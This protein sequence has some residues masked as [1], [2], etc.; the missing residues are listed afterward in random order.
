MHF[1][2]VSSYIDGWGP[3]PQGELETPLGIGDFATRHDIEDIQDFGAIFRALHS[4]IT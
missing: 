2:E 3:P 1:D 4:K